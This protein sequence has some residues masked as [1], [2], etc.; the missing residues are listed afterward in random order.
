MMARDARFRKSI[1][2]LKPT[3]TALALKLCRETIFM[4]LHF[5]LTTYFG[6]LTSATDQRGA[7]TTNSWDALGRLTQRQSFDVGGS[8]F[9]RRRIFL[10]SRQL[11]SVL[12]QCFG[13]S[14]KNSIYQ[15]GAARIQTKCGRLNQW[16]DLLFG[17]TYPRRI[18]RQRRLLA[19]N[20]QR[21]KLGCHSASFIQ[22]QVRRWQQIRLCLTAEA[23]L[24]SG[25]TREATLLK[26][27]LMVWTVSKFRLARPLL[28]V[29]SYQLGNPPVWHHLLCH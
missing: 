6:N 4:R 5:I 19:D 26:I 10:R 14:D 1:G 17:W 16:L 20:L 24:H 25:R 18:S 27:R 13:R 9:W 15:H 28:P 2:A 3:P 12:H 22:R 29:S 11:G 7:L 8:T 23:T 21:R